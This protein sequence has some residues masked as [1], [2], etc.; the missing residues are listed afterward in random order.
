MNTPEAIVESYMNAIGERDF[1][2]ARG[3]LSD[4]NFYYTSPIGNYDDADKFIHSLFGI[5]PVLEKVEIEKLFTNG[6]EVMAII[7]IMTTLRGYTKY[8]LAMWFRIE[9]TRIAAID[10]IFDASAYKEMF[11]EQFENNDEN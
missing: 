10:A 8:H 2:K 7:D 3:Y 5:G 11:I 6:N 1:D 9:K 4:N